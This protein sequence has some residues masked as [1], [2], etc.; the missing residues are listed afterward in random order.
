MMSSSLLPALL[1]I[2][3]DGRITTGGTA[4]CV[5]IRFS[6]LAGQRRRGG[7]SQRTVPQAPRRGTRRHTQVDGPRGRPRAP[8]VEVEQIDVLLEDRLEERE[9]PDRVQV[10][11]R[12]AD[13]RPERLVVLPGLVKLRLEGLEE[14]RVLAVLVVD[15]LEEGA[16]ALDGAWAAG[17]GWGG[18]G[19]VSVCRGG[20]GG[21]GGALF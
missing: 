17:G 2:S 16:G 5:T 11:L 18:V 19:D 9:D 13:V 7:V 10:L 20:R 3:T 6:G 21:E 12:L 4:M 8:V 1:S 14:R 15:D